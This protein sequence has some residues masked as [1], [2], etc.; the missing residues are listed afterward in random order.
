MIVGDPR[1]FREDIIR[2]TEVVLEDEVPTPE[3]KDAELGAYG[4]LY[5]AMV[6]LNQKA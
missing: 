5:G 1:I 4:G 3:I 6:L 2:H